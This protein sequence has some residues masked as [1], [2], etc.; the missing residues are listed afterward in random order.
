MLA[1][2]SLIWG[3]SW[4][5]NR[6]G[7]NYSGPMNFAALRVAL[8]ALSLFIIMALTGRSLRLTHTKFNVLLGLL[9]TSFF[10]ACTS[11]AVM[12]AGT[13]KTTVLVFVMPFW[14]LLL[15]WI[16]LG[17]RIQGLQWFAVLLALAGLLLI[18]APWQFHGNLLSSILAL[19]AGIAWAVSSV[20]LKRYR[21][22]HDIDVYSMT[23]WQLAIGAIPLALLAWNV[24][25]PPIQW[26]WQFIACLS[27]SGI[28][29]TA[30]GWVIW[31]KIL[32]VLPA[33]TASMSTLAIPAISV[34]GAALQLGEHPPANEIQGM[35]LIAAALALLSYLSV[36]QHRSDD[37]ALGNE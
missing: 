16:F 9:Q 28:G 35:L 33:G 15:A 34:I 3:Y 20:L 31:M 21:H 7:M 36:R 29:A 14:T 6:I 22:D 18:L 24:P 17:E 37:P 26:T 10:F 4:I 32:Q 30:L 2:L 25:S 5:T 12:H 23:A 8:G 1:L 13:G 19:L 27:F 11:W